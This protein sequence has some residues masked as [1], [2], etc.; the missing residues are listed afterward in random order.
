MIPTW[1][2]SKLAAG[3]HLAESTEVLLASVSLPEAN[4]IWWQAEAKARENVRL[5]NKAH[6]FEADVRYQQA[7]EIDSLLAHGHESA[8]RC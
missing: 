8:R 6:V 4:Q 2:R 5:C 1:A 7:I 3:R